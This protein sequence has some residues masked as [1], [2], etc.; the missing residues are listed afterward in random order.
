MVR[1]IRA[2]NSAAANSRHPRGAGTAV[3]PGLLPPRLPG[4]VGVEAV[5]V[6][7]DRPLVGDLQADRDSASTDRRSA[8]P[9]SSEEIVLAHVLDHRCGHESTQALA[10]DSSG[11]S[12]TPLIPLWITGNSPLLWTTRVVSTTLAGARCSTN[13]TGEWS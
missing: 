2:P 3:H 13:Q 4:L 11:R 5:G 12:R 7:D 9:A 6:V 10:T 1:P 8:S